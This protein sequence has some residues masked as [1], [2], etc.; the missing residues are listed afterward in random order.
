[1]V[2]N[3]VKKTKNYTNEQLRSVV[4]KCANGELNP[5]LASVIYKIPRSTINNHLK[6][7]STSFTLGRTPA[8]AHSQE[9][10][11]VN[12][13]CTLSDWAFGADEDALVTIVRDFVREK[14][15][16]TPFKNDTPGPDWIYG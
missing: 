10:A 11:I 5:N 13:L 16:K 15:L 6:G 14:K 8:L 1:M 9:E 2:R 12:H 3:Y 7:K 4:D